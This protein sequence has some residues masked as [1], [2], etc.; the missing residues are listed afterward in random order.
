MPRYTIGVPI[1]GYDA[2]FIAKTLYFAFKPAR[3]ISFGV[4]LPGSIE[5]TIGK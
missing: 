3:R 5:Q 2:Q 4:F 1:P